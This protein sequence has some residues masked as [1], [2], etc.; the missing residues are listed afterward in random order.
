MIVRRLTSITA[1]LVAVSAFD[2]PLTGQDSVTVVAGD[3]SAGWLKRLFFGSD[4]R[5]LWS[6]PIRVP[7]LNLREYAGGLTP[8]RTG[9]YGQTISLHFDGADGRRHVFRS[10]D[11]DLSR[12]LAE[13]LLG[14]FVEDIIQDQ[15]SAYNP[16]AALVTSPLVEAAGVLAASPQIFVMPDD[17][18]LGEFREA[19]AGMLGMIMENPDEGPQNTPGF[20]GSELV[21]GSDRVLEAT[22]KS[23]RDRIDEIGF[24]KA[25]LLDVYLGDRDRHKGQW[26]WARFEEGDGYRW[27]VV[28]EDRDQP[29]VKQDGVIL[30]LARTF[31]VRKLTNFSASYNNLVGL[32]WNGW[33][34][35]RRFFAGL[36]KPVWDSVAL[37]LQQR[38]TDQVIEDAVRKLPP[39]YYAL[40]GAELTYELKNRRDNLLEVADDY[41]RLMAEYVDIQ[42]TDEDEIATIDRNDDGT[43]L[44]EVA[45]TPTADPHFRRTFY[46]DETKEIRLH[47]HGGEDRA[48]VR[49]NSGDIKIRVIGGG[50]RDHLV[51]ASSAATYFYDA[52]GRTEF[53]RGQGTRVDRRD[54]QAPPSPDF[55][56]EQPPD[57]GYWL[58]PAPGMSFSPDFG[59]FVGG[60][61]HRYQYGFRKFPHG[62]HVTLVGGFAFGA[63]QPTVSLQLEQREVKHN[64]HVELGAELTGLEI[65]RFHG[66]GNESQIPDTISYRVDQKQSHFTMGLTLEPSSHVR[67]TLGG[68][69]KVAVTDRDELTFLQ[70]LGPDFY[71]TGTFAQVGAQGGVRLDFRD[72]AVASTKGLVLS[73]GGSVYGPWIDVTEGTFGEVHGE[74]AAYAT[75]WATLALR[76]AAKKVFGTFPFQEAAYLG[77]NSTLRG[78]AEQRFA[79]DASL[80]GS[81]ELRFPLTKVR[82]IFP[83]SLGLH[84]LVDVGR[85]FSDFDIPG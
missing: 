15:T 46:P 54:F 70:S 30:W 48:V 52:G 60:G 49:G 11:K 63:N 83:G 39:E 28:A 62:S 13:G 50:G 34:L 77:G 8:V 78:F 23:P 16:A 38:F 56:H 36:E 61:F 76:G 51:D 73:A 21:S 64:L 18:A 58:K 82:I 66:F 53:V 44:V 3:Y 12:R 1:L 25:R 32:T 41:Y 14:T 67:L 85:V 81:A 35:D 2:S 68:I 79:G 69:G 75:A 65:I 6:V 33:D 26:K 45:L 47:L 5:D 57:W 10:M 17:A 24:L 55:A 31:F 43:V 40:R 84:G 22:E 7:Y 71:G 42:A 19:Y 20:A 59:F 4:Y 74:V 80:L 9:G 27:E 29:F 72:R 37:D